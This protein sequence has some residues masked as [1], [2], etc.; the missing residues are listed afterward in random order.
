MY[1]YSVFLA[2]LVILISFSCDDKV[3]DSDNST[4][5]EGEGIFI[6]NEGLYNQA[7]SSVY[8]Y[9]Y[10]KDSIYP[11]V[12]QKANNENIGDVL[13]SMQISGDKA[14]LIVNN[15]GLVRKVNIPDFKHIKTTSGLTSP[16]QM[17]KISDSKAYI[18]DIFANKINVYSLSED[19]LTGEIK[20]GRWIENFAMNGKQIFASCPWAFGKPVSKW[21][22]VI[23]SEKDKLTDSIKTGI[24]PSQ[25][26]I[27]KNG[28]LW[29]LCIGNS[30]DG[31]KGSLFKS[32]IKTLKNVDSLHFDQVLN[33][34]N[35]GMQLNQSKDTLYVMYND[36]MK[37]PVSGKIIA[38]TVVNRQNENF[39]GLGIDNKRHLLY[40]TDALNFAEKGKV[41]IYSK[42]GKL[43]KTLSAGY[44]PNMVIPY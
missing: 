36:V 27:D 41:Y 8:Y 44:L 33:I 30:Y 20:T 16:R 29:T 25:V 43:I 21:I 15:S 18:S 2:I 7:N 19:K 37:I 4:F 10:A 26:V 40:V 32:D 39:Y 38:E 14:Y 28:F 17:I 9:H 23:D 35:S 22:Y 12:F 11:D 13:Q 1:K 42:K 34:F 24:S 31:I 3:P 5:V 6:V